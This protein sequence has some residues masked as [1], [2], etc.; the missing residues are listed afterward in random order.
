MTTVTG[1]A[2]KNYQAGVVSK[3]AD[4]TD[5]VLALGTDT[6]ASFDIQYSDGTTRKGR[7]ISVPVPPGST[8]EAELL[9]AAKVVIER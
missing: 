9:A 4:E 6:E 1:L 7:S 2:I 5:V 8:L 3:F